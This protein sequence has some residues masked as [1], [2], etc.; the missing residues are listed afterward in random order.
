[1]RQLLERAD[2]LHVLE[3][4]FASACEGAGGTV[5]ICGS[6]GMGKTSLVQRFLAD[7]DRTDDVDGGRGASGARGAT[8]F[9]GGCDDL[10]A[11]RSFGPFRDMARTSGL[12]DD[13]LVRN[14]N[15][16]DLLAG[17]MDVLDR[18]TRPAVMVVEDAHWADDA[19]IDVLRYLSRRLIS[20]HA[21]LVVT[22]RDREV[23]RSHPVRGLLAG[24][25][26]TAP[27]RID[28]RP[29]SL[30]AVTEMVDHVRADG[31]QPEL[32]PRALH[33]VSGGNPYLVVQLLL[34]DPGDAA[35]SARETLVARAER[36]SPEG[37]EVLQVLSV[38]PDGADPTVARLLFGDD[39]A[40]LHEAEGSGLLTST[41]DRIRFRHQLGR[42]A[43]IESM[44]F[45]E[46]MASTN[47]VL[48]A[49]ISS[50]ADP[51]LLVH[52][53]RA[54]GDGRRATRFAIE[55]LDDGLAPTNHREIWK[56]TRIALECT[57]DLTPMR[58]AELHLAAARSGRVTN[59]HAEAVTNAEQAVDLLT[60]H[61]TDDPTLASAWLTLA[62]TRAATGDHHRSAEALHRA[63]ELLDHGAVTD[64]WVRCNTLMASAAL[65]AGDVDGSV[66]RATESIEL[67]DTNGWTQELV[68]AL[69][70][71]SAAVG[72]PVTGAGAADMERALR[73]GAVHGPPDRHAA[74]LHNQS[75]LLL[76]NAET[77]RAEELVDEAERYSREHGLDNLLF[78]AQ[79]QRAHILINQGRTGEA[80]ALVN[81]LV[82]RATD[83]GS[84]KASADAALARIW[85]RRGDP[86]AAPLVE[87][88]WTDAVATGEI[89]KIAIAGLTRLEHEWLQGDD[90][91]LRRFAN[92]LAGLGER[93]QHHRLRADA[94]RMLMRLGEPVEPFDGCPRPLAAAL[95]G[96]HR[97]A[98]ELW[99]EAG[100]PYERALELVE[101]T[102]TPIAF[103][104]LRLL[105]RAGATR[106][107]DLL[108][109]RL[110]G[111]GV[112]GVPRGPRKSADGAVPVLTDR[113]ADVLKLIA[114]G[115]TN[116]QIADELFV[117]RRTVDNHVSAILSRL[118]AEG[119]HEAVEEAA[120]QG[121][122]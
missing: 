118:G 67:A 61:G 104:G 101:S 10:I 117:A 51:S 121:L 49:L 34:A 83:P 115:M 93:H 106:T 23:D 1:M 56:L 27:E 31:R 108:R 26:S 24:P 37:R 94:L 40:A 112:Q 50:G 122:L 42:T 65:I 6:A 38:L 19:S 52:L 30:T 76:R 97:L 11:P 114:T 120:A 43:I 21:L 44:S 98:A 47:Q 85:A 82:E 103:E 22:L 5:V 48:D 119:R 109:Q 62:M 15:R 59:N 7:L 78:H 28:L 89:Q 32:E 12:L 36:L 107:A 72:G 33:E 87:R 77:A 71:R 20:M 81:E 88:A 46:R 90:E 116:Q 99:A 58:I 29:L 100:Q 68:Y 105:D 17:L 86:T 110:R 55:V 39:P 73:L 75:V 54:A 70:V 41:T 95:A 84:I 92:H 79:V 16:E 57:T 53:S 66:A 111:R 18:P 25:T 35:R 96:D 3:S 91:S 113:Q 64:E 80:E 102:D 9:L 2:D 14:P 45:G 69:G 63:K 8:V 13:E 4:S 60:E 74:N